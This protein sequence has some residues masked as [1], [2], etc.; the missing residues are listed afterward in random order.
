MKKIFLLGII[1]VLFVSCVVT[2]TTKTPNYGKLTIGMSMYQVQNLIGPPERVLSLTRTAHGY[3]EIWQYRTAYNEVFAL[4]FLN[5]ILEGYQFLY[6]DYQYAPSPYYYRPSYGRPIFPDY[7]PNRPIYRPYPSSP[8]NNRPPSNTQ[9]PEYRP[10]RPE[11]GRPGSSSRPETTTPPRPETT[12]PGNNQ[13]S[14]SG[15]RQPESTGTRNN[16]GQEN[17]QTPRQNT[18]SN[19]NSSETT[20]RN[21]SR[22]DS[23]TNNS[24]TNSR[25]NSETNTSRSGSG[26]R[27]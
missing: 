23:N 13:N 21:S 6:E 27:N 11:T 10:P 25:G 3:E 12:R 8:D 14:N 9:H 5:E 20:T 4:E 26:S 1:S 15:G 2:T 18:N 24:G 19:T 22:D 17:N 7:R 16:S